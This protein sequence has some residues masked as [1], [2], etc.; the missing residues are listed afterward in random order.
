[1]G[2]QV[3]TLPRAERGELRERVEGDRRGDRVRGGNSRMCFL[4]VVLVLGLEV[5]MN[6][7]GLDEEY[8]LSSYIGYSGGIT[9][10]ENL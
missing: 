8:I 3:H 4:M 6:H 10:G 2:E 7:I 9:Y 1:M 5:L